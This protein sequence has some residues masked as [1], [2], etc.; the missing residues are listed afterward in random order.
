MQQR[1]V[2]NLFFVYLLRLPYFHSCCCCVAYMFSNF[3][4]FSSLT[5]YTRRHFTYARPVSSGY[6]NLAHKENHDVKLFIYHRVATTRSPPAPS[7]RRW[8]VGDFSY[9]KYSVATLTRRTTRFKDNTAHAS[10]VQ[11]TSSPRY[12]YHTPGGGDSTLLWTSPTACTLSS[13]Y[14]RRPRRRRPREHTQR[15]QHV[16]TYATLRLYYPPNGEC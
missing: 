16:R 6:W 13:N 11:C 7:P 4:C 8:M 15:E 2:I 12:Y 1:A 14:R 3:F 10:K 9:T 5:F